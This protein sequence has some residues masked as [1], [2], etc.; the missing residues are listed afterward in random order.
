MTFGKLHNS[1]LP[2]N[3]YLE[4]IL[5]NMKRL[6]DGTL[7]SPFELNYGEDLCWFVFSMIIRAALQ[8]EIVYYKVNSDRKVC[9]YETVVFI[10]DAYGDL[11]L[12]LWEENTINEG[13]LSQLLNGLKK[14]HSQRLSVNDQRVFI[15]RI[16]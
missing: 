14:G 5:A 9:V 15:T 3:L 11:S 6:G 1:S 2:Q 8:K 13:F 16:A 12:A 4:A 10:G 7:E